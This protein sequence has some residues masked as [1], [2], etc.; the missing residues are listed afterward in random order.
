MLQRKKHYCPKLFCCETILS[1][2]VTFTRR[3]LHLNET[4]NQVTAQC[5]E[6]I[7]QIQILNVFLKHKVKTL[8]CATKNKE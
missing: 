6:P 7:I 1:G 3:S 5:L 4:K 2:R 8:K